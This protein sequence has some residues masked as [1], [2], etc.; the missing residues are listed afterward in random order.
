MNFSMIFWTVMSPRVGWAPRRAHASGG[1]D[2]TA[3]VTSASEVRT[4]SSS[5]DGSVFR[6]RSIAS[7][8]PASV[9]TRPNGTGSYVG[10]R[11]DALSLREPVRRELGQVRPDLAGFPLLA[12][13][14][15]GLG[16][17]GRR[18][19]CGVLGKASLGIG[20]PR[21]EGVDVRAHRA[22][23]STTGAVSS[24]RRSIASVTVSPGSR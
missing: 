5:A 17:A 1:K 21:D 10:R 4:R 15:V 18:W 12:A 3:S 14:R 7:M 11:D 20:Q 19:L 13:T 2:R 8:R 22:G 9:L 6:S 24:P 23:R 16:Q